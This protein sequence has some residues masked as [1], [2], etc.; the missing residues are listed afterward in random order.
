MERNKSIMDN[1]DNLK[2]FKEM[3]ENNLYSNSKINNVGLYPI[4]VSF[5]RQNRFK[6]IH[7]IFKDDES[8]FIRIE[9]DK[10]GNQKQWV[11][12]EE[13]FFKNN[14]IGTYDSDLIDKY[15]NLDGC[16][17]YDCEK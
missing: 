15:F 8:H 1:I 10:D 6:T 11:D 7:K 4:V 17:N 5:Y 2:L 12:N 16:V 14:I 13:V 3:F 9:I